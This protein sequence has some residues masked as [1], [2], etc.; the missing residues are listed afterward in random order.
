MFKI[1]DFSKLAQISVKTLRYYDQIG[2]FGPAWIDRFTGYRYY[3]LEQ[4]PRLNRIVALKDLGFSLEQIQPLLNEDLQP[5]ELRGML[6]LKQSEIE[7]RISDEQFR[8]QRI[9]ARLRQIEDESGMPTYDIVLKHVACLQVVGLRRIVPDNHSIQQLLADLYARLKA[10]T[11]LSQ[12]VG[13]GLVLYYDNEYKES[14]LDVEFAYPF[15]KPVA[16]IKNLNFHLLPEVETMACFLHRGRSVTLPEAYRSLMTW[17]ELNGYRLDGPGREVYLQPADEITSSGDAFVEVQFPVQK[18]PIPFIT[19]LLKENKTMEV[20]IVTLP[21]FQA[22]GLLY[23][24]KNQNNEIAGLWQ[25]FNQRMK[26]IKHC[27]SG[28]YGLCEPMDP[29]GNFRYL[30][31]MGVSDTTDIPAGMQVWQVPEQMYAVFPCTLPSVGETHR[32]A[33]DTWIPGSEYQYNGGFDF[34]LYDEDFDPG[35]PDSAM[36]VYVPIEKRMK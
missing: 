22:V 2:L 9:E 18:K 1:G 14:D 35:K 6:R 20:K 24:G 5:S 15:D 17:V 10:G 34:E 16:G 28:A 31:A 23:H 19:T 36:F 3:A 30:A 7:Q 29:A 21:G 11:N 26:E 33:F 27:T 25:E 8:L 32:Y 4:L 12:I 13:P